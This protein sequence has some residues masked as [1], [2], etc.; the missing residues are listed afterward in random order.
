MFTYFRFHK[1]DVYFVGLNI[2]GCHANISITLNM[3]FK[4]RNLLTL[5]IKVILGQSVEKKER[6]KKSS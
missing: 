2:L 4:V 3:K 6:E 1:G 5:N